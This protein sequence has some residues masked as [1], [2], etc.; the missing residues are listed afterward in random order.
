MKI[1]SVLGNSQKLDGGAMYGNCP[2][3]LWSRWSPPDEQHRIALACRAMLIRDEDRL[4]LAEAG[5]GVY[6]EP[7]L[8]ERFGVVE[9]RHVLLESLQQL[10]IKP[11]DITHVV[12]SHLHFDHVGG[13]LDAYKA[14]RAAR[15][16]FSNAQW[17]VGARAFE[18]ACHPHP[19][20]RAS[21]IPGFAQRL[22]D[23]GRLH[24]VKGSD[25]HP[26]GASYRFRFSDGHTPGMMHLDIRGPQRVVFAADLVPGTPW[27]HAPITMGYDRYPEALVDEKQLL[28]TELAE[29]GGHLF[30]T[31]DPNTAMSRVV[32]DERGRFRAAEPMAT[33]S[34]WSPE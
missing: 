20:D 31:H 30:F 25:D 17:L 34:G 7:S 13:C 15:L 1:D 33:V 8:K 11:E 10:G 29:E 12:L 28:L 2:R 26:L 22:E 23:T 24:L 5:I 19:R 16:I 6:M 14:G 9:K 27:I 4:I 3:V 18:R 32:R 21:F